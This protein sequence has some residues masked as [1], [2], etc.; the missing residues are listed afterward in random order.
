M[1]FFSTVKMSWSCLEMAGKPRTYQALIPAIGKEVRD[2]EARFSGLVRRDE[3]GGA[4]GL[5]DGGW[6]SCAP[7]VHSEGGRECVREEKVRGSVGGRE[8]TSG[9]SDFR[10][11]GSDFLK[12]KKTFI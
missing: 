6:K 9:R 1:V 2:E 12:G 3:T 7:C 8:S 10:W 4:L 5:G 11:W